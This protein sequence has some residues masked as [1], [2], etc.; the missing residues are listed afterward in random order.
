MGQVLYPFGMSNPGL[1][2][3]VEVAC[4]PKLL[5]AMDSQ[6]HV[7][8]LVRRSSVVLALEGISFLFPIFLLTIVKDKEERILVMMKMVRPG[9]RLCA[10]AGAGQGGGKSHA[11]WPQRLSAG[12]VW[13]R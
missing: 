13:A 4:V 10:G 9:A 3:A 7:V 8:R 1:E 6:A 11:V 12:G 5:R 2:Y